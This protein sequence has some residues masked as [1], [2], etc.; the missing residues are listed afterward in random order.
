MCVCVL[1]GIWIQPSI[2]YMLGVSDLDGNTQRT[3]VPVIYI[4]LSTLRR[5]NLESVHDLPRPNFQAGESAS[6]SPMTNLV[7]NMSGT[8]LDSTPKRRFTVNLGNDNTSFRSC[9]FY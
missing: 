5:L 3:T 1:D 7:R 9:W 6:M 2:C 4:K 8:S